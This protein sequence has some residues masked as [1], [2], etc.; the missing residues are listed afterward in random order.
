MVMT[1]K[2]QYNYL[3][4]YIR[5]EDCFSNRILYRMCEE[6]PLHND[7]DVITG[8]I[9]I[10]GR[11]YAAA[12]ERRKASEEEELLGTES[13]YD[14]VVGPQMLGIGDDL[15]SQLN[16]LRDS[17]LSVRD[18]L[19]DILVLHKFLVDTFWNISHLEKHSLASKYLHFHC[20]NKFFIYDSRAHNAINKIVQ[21]PDKSSLA[22]LNGKID[23]VYGDFVIRMIE[24]QE[25]F[26]TLLGKRY[27]PRELDSFLLKVDQVLRKSKQS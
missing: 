26:E 12:I 7:S 21:R 14:D 23:E 20:P 17:K 9:M 19:V 25:H 15:D 5:E 8:K 22:R 3:L 18:D 1:I 2:D 13:F 16:N 10:I 4:N 24:L 27:S 11:T 6:N